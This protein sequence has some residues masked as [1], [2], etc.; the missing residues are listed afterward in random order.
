MCFLYQGD[1]GGPLVCERGG[2][3]SLVGISSWV[4]TG[5]KVNYPGVFA[6]VPTLKSWIE[7]TVSSNWRAHARWIV[8]KCFCLSFPLFCCLISSSTP[9]PFFPFFIHG[10]YN[11]MGTIHTTSVYFCKSVIWQQN[12]LGMHRYIS[13]T[14]VQADIGRYQSISVSANKALMAVAD[15]YLL[16][17]G[18]HFALAILV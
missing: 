6:R 9:N 16:L 8:L 3:W 14:S 5:C 12:W 11:M 15:I 13:H 4:R 10:N 1:S 18:I 2:V 17:I 7:R